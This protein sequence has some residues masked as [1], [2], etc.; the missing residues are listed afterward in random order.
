MCRSRVR[1]FALAVGLIPCVASLVAAQTATNDQLVARGA[2]SYAFYCAAC[3]GGN[4]GGDAAGHV[5][6]LAGRSAASLVQETS[7]LRDAAG[8]GKGDAH[9]ARVAQL[10]TEQIEGIAEYLASLA[11]PP[12][13]AH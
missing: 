13:A 1:V 12:S 11:P 2:L 10:N 6:R 9:H 4:G 7:A 3:H 8:N 5:P